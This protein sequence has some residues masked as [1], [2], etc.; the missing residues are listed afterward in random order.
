MNKIIL[1]GRL[2]KDVELRY[3]QTS[4]TAVASFTLA[5]NRRFVKE[6]EERQTDFINIVAW[7]KLAET[8]SNYL[9]KGMQVVVTGRLQNRSWD[10]EQGQKRYVTEVIVEELE[11]VESKKSQGADDS[12]LNS[13][14]LVTA[15]ESESVSEEFISNGDDLPF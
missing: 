10:D 9:K 1:L 6:G 2:T 15:K 4:N 14:T 12:I 5:V 3:T 8:S 11:F 7:N 13:S